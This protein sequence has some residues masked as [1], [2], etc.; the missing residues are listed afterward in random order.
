MARSERG[1]VSAGM[2]P[3][4]VVILAMVL[5]SMIVAEPTQY[6]EAAGWAS[7]VALKTSDLGPGYKQHSGSYFSGTQDWL[8]VTVGGDRRVYTDAIARRHGWLES[9]E[10]SFKRPA[11]PS[12]LIGADYAMYQSAAGAHADYTIIARHF[13]TVNSMA[14][15]MPRVGDES[16]GFSAA[17]PSAAGYVDIFRVGR[18]VVRLDLYGN[19]LPPGRAV[20]NLARVIVRRI[21]TAG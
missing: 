9:Y 15:P 1:E 13:H 17:Q 18:Y 7:T 19:P 12:R 10:Q 14:I 4:R 20:V 2:K 6:G 11:K 5:A 21:R 8:L 3:H 16:T